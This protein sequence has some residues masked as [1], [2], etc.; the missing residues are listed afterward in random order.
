MGKEDK[1]HNLFIVK[2]NDSVIKGFRDQI[3]VLHL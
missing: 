1:V 2:R 3:I